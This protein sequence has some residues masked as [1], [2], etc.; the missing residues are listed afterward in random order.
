MILLPLAK[1]SRSSG[2][3]LR[4]LALAAS[5]AVLA[6]VYVGLA[7]QWRAR[8]APRDGSIAD[9]LRSGFRVGP[10]RGRKLH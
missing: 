7:L 10:Q 6:G 9:A 4:G 2:V 3:Y 8:A 5:V 1:N